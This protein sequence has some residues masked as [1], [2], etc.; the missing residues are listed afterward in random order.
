MVVIITFPR[1][2]KGGISYL[3]SVNVRKTWRLFPSG[4]E[5][6]RRSPRWRG[7]SFCL[8]PYDTLCAVPINGPTFRV[9]RPHVAGGVCEQR[10]LAL[11]N[12]I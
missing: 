2:R 11:R 5:F 9:V 3:P 10:Y 8:P 12:Y 6:V 7:L 4:V 1:V